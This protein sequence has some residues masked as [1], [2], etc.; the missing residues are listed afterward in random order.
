[1]S[2]H[3]ASVRIHNIESAGGEGARQFG[4]HLLQATGVLP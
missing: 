3:A 1:V 2:E 4:R